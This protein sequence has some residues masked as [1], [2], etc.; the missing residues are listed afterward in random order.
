MATIPGTMADLA[1]HA[2]TKKAEQAATHAIITKRTANMR[3]LLSKRYVSETDYL[4]LEQERIQQTQDLAAE[5]QR[6]KQLA[7]A[8]A[9]VQQQIKALAA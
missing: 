6:L 9:E 2:C 3:D 7:A 1:E 8:E 4:Q 5:K